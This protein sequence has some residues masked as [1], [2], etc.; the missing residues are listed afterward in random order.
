[1]RSGSCSGTTLALQCVV[2]SASPSSSCVVKLVA[3]TYCSF[4]VPASEEIRAS[5]TNSQDH[6]SFAGAKVVYIRK[7]YCQIQVSFSACSSFSGSAVC[8]LRKQSTEARI[9]DRLLALLLEC[10]GLCLGSEVNAGVILLQP[11]REVFEHMKQEVECREHPEHIVTTSPEQDYL[12]RF[13]WH[14]PHWT[15]IDVIYNF[16]LHHLAL[17]LPDSQ[18]DCERRQVDFEDVRILHFSAHPKPSQRDPEMSIEDFVEQLLGRYEGVQINVHH[19]PE[20]IKRRNRSGKFPQLELRKDGSEGTKLFE[21]SQDASNLETPNFKEVTVAPAAFQAL[22][23]FVSK[24]IRAW[25]EAEEQC[26][27]RHRGPTVLE[28]VPAKVGSELQG[29]CV[30]WN[31]AKGFGRVSSDDGS[32]PLFVHFSELPQASAGGR[33]RL[34]LGEPVSFRVG[35]DEKRRLTAKDVKREID[36]AQEG[37][38]HTAV[39]VAE[40]AA[41]PTLPER[42]YGR[43]VSWK[44][45]QKY[46]F[47]SFVEDGKTRE[48]MLHHSDLL[49]DVKGGISLEAGQGVNFQPVKDEGKH[50]NKLRATVA[51]GTER[52]EELVC[53]VREFAMSDASSTCFPPGTSWER[54]LLHQVAAT[55]AL[56][57][58][59]EGEGDRR[60]VYMSKTP[61]DGVSDS[62]LKLSKLQARIEEIA[63]T[64]K[65]ADWRLLV[66]DVTGH[67]R[68][69]LKDF[70]W[71]R[72]LQLCRVEAPQGEP[73][74][75]FVCKQPAAPLL[76]N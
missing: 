30:E 74:H 76:F 56:F 27:K 17:R 40:E 65:L 3:C 48:I 32:K 47:V 61:L 26:Q 58:R 53:K 29:I 50:R 62:D 7:F 9:A 41:A 51:T 11:D 39:E 66:E 10:G 70:C 71:Q 23:Q 25:S 72:G 46:G 45:S 6:G 33:A 67:E 12:T 75:H 52:D 2:W 38:S 35:M 1:M 24:S 49:M 19:D 73:C 37:S 69:K 22:R 68:E 20:A 16:Q 21:V 54:S 36:V 63:E 43:C 15:H 44:T 60:F 28:P 18:K 59:S 57:T 55:M 34:E 64:Q 31:H 5:K 8:A 13:F 4:R 14:T 42:V